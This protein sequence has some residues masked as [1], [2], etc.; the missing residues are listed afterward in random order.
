M[1]EFYRPAWTSNIEEMNMSLSR[2]SVFNKHHATSNK[3][4]T[5]LVTIPFKNNNSASTMKE[6]WS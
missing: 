1:Y 5:K 2:K 6:L 3:N 4:N